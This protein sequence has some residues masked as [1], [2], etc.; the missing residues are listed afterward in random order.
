MLSSMLAKVAY[1]SPLPNNLWRLGRGEKKVSDSVHIRIFT[2]TF[3]LVTNRSCA[4]FYLINEV[5]QNMVCRKWSMLQW[6]WQGKT[7]VLGEKFVPVPLCPTHISH[8][9]LVSNPGLL[10]ETETNR[11]QSWARPLDDRIEC[12]WHSVLPPQRT[13]CAAIITTDRWMLFT[14]TTA[15]YRKDHTEVTAWAKCRTFSV[16]PDGT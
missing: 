4:E 11:L 15:V 1:T 7:K 12:T 14:Q 6:Y 2:G 10:A 8:I 3:H 9:H 13:V 16:N 5:R